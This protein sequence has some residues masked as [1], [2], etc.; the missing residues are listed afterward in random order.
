MTDVNLSLAPVALYECAVEL[1]Q[2]GFRP[3]QLKDLRDKLKKIIEM[4]I[5]DV[6]DKFQIPLPQSLSNFIIPGK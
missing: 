5:Q 1:V 3:D 2:A 6:I 4:T